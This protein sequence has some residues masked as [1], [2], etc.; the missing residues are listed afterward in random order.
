MDDSESLE[1]H[2]YPTLEGIA[3]DDGNFDLGI[4]ND[5]FLTQTQSLIIM[6]KK[7]LRNSNR[8]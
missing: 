2:Y 5:G 7:S 1:F 3:F 8:E 4:W 6:G